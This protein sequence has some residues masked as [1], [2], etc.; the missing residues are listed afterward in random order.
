[1]AEAVGKQNIIKPQAGL[2]EKLVAS[3]LDVVFAGGSMAAGK[4]T[5]LT[6]CVC[7]P[8]GFR[9][10]GD[11][12]VGDILTNPDTGGME[13]IIQLH[14]IEKVP[15]YHIVFS[16]G[17]SVDCSEGHLWKIRQTGRYTKRRD[18]SGNR[19]DWRLW[20]ARMIYEW[21]ERKKNGMYKNNNIAIPL[22]AP[23]QFSRPA[24]PTTPRPIPPYVLG[25]LLGDGCLCRTLINQGKVELTTMD[26]EIVERFAEHYD[27]S[28]HNAKKDNRAKSYFIVD[29]GLI[30]AI[31]V[32]RLDGCMSENKFIPEAYKFSTIAER[33]E[34]ICGLMD[35]DG[36]VDGGGN[37]QYTTI[38]KQLA[39]DVAFVI[40]SLGGRAS[41]FTKVPTF[42]SDGEK[43]EGRLAYNVSISTPFNDEL[44]YLTRK[45]QRIRGY[46]NLYLEKYVKSIEP[47]GEVEGRCITVDNPSGLYIVTDGFIVT[48]NSFG[49][50]LALAEP[51]M[52]PNFRAVFLRRNLAETKTA[53]GLFEDTKK[54]YTDNIKSDKVSDNPRITFNSGAFVEFTHIS[55]ESPEKL[56]ERIRG[57]QFDLIYFDEGTSFEWSTFRLLFSRNRGTAKWTNKIRL[58]CNP[59]KRHWIR[60]FIKDY[61]GAD[62]F[63]KPDW[64]GRVRY[65]YIKGK[66]V[67][68]VVWGDTK[69]EVYAQCR[70]QID[71]AVEKFNAKGGKVDYKSMIKSFTFYLGSPAEN[72]A[73]VGKNSGYLGSVAAMG[74]AEARANLLGNWNVDLDED[75]EAPLKNAEI[76]AVF[77]ADPQINNDKWITMDLADTGTDNTLILVWNGFH[78]VGYKILMKSTPRM[79]AEAVEMM[80]DK[81]GIGDS[82]IIYDGVRAAYM[83][84]YIPEAVAY[85]SYRAPMG[86]YGRMAENLK[87]E[88]YLRLC[89]MV[90]RGRLSFSDSVALTVYSH[91]KMGVPINFKT[92]FCEEC[93]VI[94]FIDLPSGKKR[95]ANKKDMNKM[96]GKGRSMD[97]CDPIAMRMMPAL[98]YEYGTELEATYC[99]EAEIDEYGDTSVDIYDEGTWS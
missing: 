35:T 25:A 36:Y 8:F 60:T 75:E 80:A 87:T 83:L 67:E 50:I 37:L 51:L 24:T 49:M 78:I 14:P 66:D 55:D 52:D 93:A 88:C 82:H 46:G 45:K 61:I 42:T 11:L 85:I 39:E 54:V 26:N 15:Y 23:V 10:V 63:I 19:D 47:I 22:T 69:E 33:K 40:R 17:T 31:K 3:D 74:E 29:N 64:D 62:G 98:A 68:D 44:V 56:L 76:N 27:M 99:T 81:H 65:F 2:Q 34:L 12:K 72:T 16:D 43:K 96:L 92:E 1:M 59:K 89:E 6:D 20:D 73:M 13:R 41:I 7:T 57:W 79:N 32:L 95:I 71:E 30:D 48:H 9:K 90:K 4:Q 18:L 58:T 84:D 86:K 53:G 5:R 70:Y 28:W 94:R 21:M 91:Q 38:S 77:D 97:L